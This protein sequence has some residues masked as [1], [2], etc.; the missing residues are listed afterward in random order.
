MKVFV[1]QKFYQLGMRRFE[2]IKITVPDSHRY[3]KGYGS[4]GSKS[5]MHFNGSVQTSKAVTDCFKLSAMRDR[6]SARAETCST[7]ALCA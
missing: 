4:A 6:F 3:G 2:I 7:D 1:F 5:A